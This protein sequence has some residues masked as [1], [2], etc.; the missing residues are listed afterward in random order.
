MLASARNDAEGEEALSVPCGDP[1]PTEYEVGALHALS[2]KG[3]GAFMQAYIAGYARLSLLA[4]CNCP[5]SPE[6]TKLIH[7]CRR[8]EKLGL[9][10]RSQ[11][12]SGTH[13]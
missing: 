12:C 8:P 1:S 2:R 4:I 3:E 5:A 7:A 11:P 13:R 6:A 9:G 10:S